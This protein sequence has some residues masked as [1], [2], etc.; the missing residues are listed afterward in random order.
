MDVDG[1][2]TVESVQDRSKNNSW[3]LGVSAGYGADNTNGGINGNMSKGSSKRVAEQTSLTGGTVNIDVAEKTTLRGAVIAS[4]TGDLTLATGSLEYSHIKDRNSSTNFG[5]GASAHTESKTTTAGKGLDSASFGFSDSRQTNFATIGEGTITVRDTSA[6]LGAGGSTDLS[7]LNRDVSKAQYSTM[8]LGVQLSADKSTIDMLSDIKGTYAETKKQGLITY[9]IGEGVVKA[10]DVGVDSELGV[11]GTLEAVVNARKDVLTIV[12]IA[13][14]KALREGIDKA[15]EKDA[16][17]LEGAVNGVSELVQKSDGVED[18]DISKVSL[19]QGDEVDNK[20][21]GYAAC[22]DKDTNSTYLNTEGTDISQG[23][24]IMNSI[25]TEAQRKDNTTNGLSLN[26]DQQVAL[27]YLRGDQAETLWNRFSET[28]N[29]TSNVGGVINWNNANAGS[30]TLVN[31]SEKAN[32]ANDSVVVPRIINLVNEKKITSNASGEF[33]GQIVDQKKND[34]YYKTH[35]IEL[36]KYMVENDYPV[37][38]DLNGVRVI[39]ND[40][41]TQYDSVL[42]AFSA[43]D[44]IG[45]TVARDSSNPLDIAQSFLPSRVV[46]EM[47]QGNYMNGP[48]VYD[49][50]GVANLNLNGSNLAVKENYV[51]FTDNYKANTKIVDSLVNQIPV[52]VYFNKGDSVA[53]HKEYTDGYKI[54]F[55]AG[56]VELNLKDSGKLNDQ[57]LDGV[58]LESFH[59]KNGELRPSK[60]V[61]KKTGELIQRTGSGVTIF[62]NE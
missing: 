51:S 26:S 38:V 21:S 6:T 17:S 40:L 16:E 59:E 13:E 32:S 29:T 9:S 1:N 61:N 14:N 27:A 2:L 22:Y 12:A 42:C 19:Y 15:L 62:E 55:S 20:L 28:A 57:K 48:N 31:G 49:Y 44:G 58:T 34:Q 8:D 52:L 7:G 25:F 45:K 3:T 46:Y 39:Q 41:G 43:A 36:I 33:E 50:A 4:D 24:D 60:I 54:N 53:Q 35:Q 18:E 56:K 5:G 23:G 30:S 37:S 10:V 11:S 47:S